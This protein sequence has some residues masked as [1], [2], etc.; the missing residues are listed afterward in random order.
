M[1]RTRPRSLLP[2]LALALLLLAPVAT[3]GTSR[4][5]GL[6]EATGAVAHAARV[7]GPLVALWQEQQDL[8]GAQASPAFTLRAP[9]LRVETDRTGVAPVNPVN[10]IRVQPTTDPPRTYA[11]AVVEGTANAAGYRWTLL[12]TD[13]FDPPRVTVASPCA[14]AH[15]ATRDAVVRQ[16]LVNLQRGAAARDLTHAVGWGCLDG[17]AVEVAG[18]FTLSLWAWNATL[19][20]ASGDT[21]LR[22]GD[23]PSWAPDPSGH[24]RAREELYLV[25]TGGTLSIPALCASGALLYTGSGST[26]VTRSLLVQV[27]SGRLDAAGHLVALRGN[28]VGVEGDAALG[29]WGAGTGK[30]FAATLDGEAASVSVDGAAVALVTAPRLPAAAQPVAWALGLLVVLWGAAEARRARLGR[31]ASWG[32]APLLAQPLTWRERR[33]TGFWALARDAATASRLRSAR[34]RVRQALRWFPDSTDARLLEAAILVKRGDY[35][36]ALDALDGVFTLMPPGPESFEV[37]AMASSSAMM[38]AR[39]QD[40]VAWLRRA[41]TADALAF[42]QEVRKPVYDPLVGDAWF[43]AARGSFASAY[44]A[45]DGLDP[46][47]S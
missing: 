9:L 10:P 14:Q 31:D 23:H 41:A 32:T 16:P 6:L 43:R 35:A 45:G 19:E 40:A 37:A 7:E 38:L 42:T 11:D 36:A 1:R 25:A 4:L 29:L 28:S 27:A 33:G 13:P 3:A 47:F 2:T 34:R 15:P 24:V 5:Q 17:A 21:D 30:P 18:N 12:A 46:A 22:S 39:H 26:L 44:L 20:S 8:L